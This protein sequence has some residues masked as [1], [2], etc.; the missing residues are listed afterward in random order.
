M[1]LKKKIMFYRRKILLALLEVFGNNISKLELQKYLFLFTRLQKNPAYDFIPYKYGCYS[2]T[3][4][5]DL[6]VMENKNNL[7]FNN[8][9]IEKIDNS[10]Y[11]DMLKFEDQKNIKKIY[12]QRLNTIDELL[13]HVYSI[14]PYYAVN[15]RMKEKILNPEELKRVKNSIPKKKEK[16]LS[17][18]GYEGISVETY[19]N[20][21]IKN[22]IR[23]LV[24]VRK[25]PQSMKFGFSQ[26]RLQHICEEVGI[27]YISIKDLGIDADKRKELIT[28]KDYDE[29]F[30]N[31]KI[32]NLSKT[33]DSQELVI[34]LLNK[35]NRVALTCFEKEVNKC[36]RTILAE[37]LLQKYHPVE[38]INHI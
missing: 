19:I 28:Q 13:Y 18:I 8:D 36:H 23:C 21:L 31:Y 34:Q 9:K 29:L 5:S 38:K 37:H 30:D 16:S 25:N 4:A 20:R 3:V 22:D 26:K 11:Y 7:I 33:N 27:K 2:F 1:I 14:A 6:A 17:T 35:Y 10:Q 32:K 12:S 15:S 24:D